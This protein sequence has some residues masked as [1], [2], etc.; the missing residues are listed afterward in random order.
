MRT[1]G[2]AAIVTLAAV[3]GACGG[4]QPPPAQPPPPPPPVAMSAPAAPAPPP[5][6]A[7]PKPSLA[8]L[9]PRTLSG[10]NDA[11]NA[12][13]SKKLADY[14]SEDCTAIDFGVPEAHGR[15]DVARSVQ[16]LFDSFG[17]AKSMATRTW[18][19]GNVAIS[20]F[21]WAGT[22]TGDLMMLKASHNPVGELR[23][24]VMWFTDDGLVREEHEYGDQAGLTA[25]IMGKK[26][27]PPVPMVP[28]NAADVHLAK[29]TADED[30]LAEW[31]KG[32]GV[33]F[34][35][36]DPTGAVSLLADDADYWLNISGRPATRGKKDLT[37]D[38][39]RW[40][41]AFPDQK[42]V[43]TNVWGIDG[44]AIVEHT[45]S[46]TQ[47]AALGQLPAS[48]RPVKDWHWLDIY[49]PNS[50]GKIKHGW[51][52]ANLLEMMMQTGGFKLGEERDDASRRR[53]SQP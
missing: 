40:F 38:L 31:A 10:I 28:T 6:P 8:E 49:Q 12:H 22:M 41:K 20:E 18:V 35:K 24:H 9:I 44:F 1:S 52:Y 4:E 42:W 27:A 32:V 15:A 19:K 50:D 25:Q 14:F 33:A 3:V 23:L 53:A 37:A 17:D 39:T 2:I 7:P 48:N 36:D 13:D 16:M 45:V 47:K 26:G 29:N 43:S 51:G 5:P 21:V 11:F 30:K 34:D 46:G